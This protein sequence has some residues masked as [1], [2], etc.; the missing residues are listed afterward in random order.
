M[1]AWATT[2]SPELCPEPA[3][4]PVSSTSFNK[5]VAYL[6]AMIPVFMT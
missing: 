6:E 1:R 5:A 3:E 4:G 2:S